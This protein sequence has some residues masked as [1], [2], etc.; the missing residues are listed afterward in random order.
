MQALLI[1]CNRRDVTHLVDV[2]EDWKGDAD[3]VLYGYT[4]KNQ[5]GFILMHWN[6]LISDTFQEKQLKQDPGIID[7]LVYEPFQEKA[8]ST[9]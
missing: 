4:N 3:I 8:T 2:L 6:Q 7:Y 1:V 5:D 9:T